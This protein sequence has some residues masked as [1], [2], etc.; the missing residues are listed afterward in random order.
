MLK[1]RF[2]LKCGACVHHFR[3]NF[4]Q[5]LKKLY[6]KYIKLYEEMT[7][8]LVSN[9]V[10]FYMYFLSISIELMTNFWDQ[11]MHYSLILFISY[12]YSVPSK[13]SKTIGIKCLLGQ[14]RILR[15]QMLIVY[16][17]KKKDLMLWIYTYKVVFVLILNFYI[18]FLIHN[19][20][21]FN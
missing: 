20:L 21:R 17:W 2:I 11:C 14:Y 18:I 4:S 12:I 6:E 16:F 1:S 3:I 7:I 13:T 8:S 15:Y 9:F 5:E 10:I 19:V